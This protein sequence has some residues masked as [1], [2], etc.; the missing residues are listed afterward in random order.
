MTSIDLFESKQIAQIASKRGFHRIFLK[1][2]MTTFAVHDMQHVDLAA[3]ELEERCRGTRRAALPACP[4]DAGD[5]TG[6]GP[7]ALEKRRK[8]APEDG[9][10]KTS[11]HSARDFL[12]RAES[13]PAYALRMDLPAY[14]A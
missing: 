3:L 12:L 1:A 6:G 14:T 10:S 7:T 11:P 4:D 2:V 8:A 9:L 5:P 13:T